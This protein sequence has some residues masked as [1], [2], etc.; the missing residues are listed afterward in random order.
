MY[1][2]LIPPAGAPGLGGVSVTSGLEYCGTCSPDP[3]FLGLV[4]HHS[5]A[6]RVVLSKA[7]SSSWPSL[8]EPPCLLFFASR[9]SSKL[10]LSCKAVLS[11]APSFLALSLPSIHQIST[12]PLSKSNTPFYV[13]KIWEFLFSLES[14]LIFSVC[15]TPT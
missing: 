2:L 5:H 15:E 4:I 6:A 14:Q 9:K 12:L 8:G 3:S 1:F 7:Q 13:S 11:G 10:N